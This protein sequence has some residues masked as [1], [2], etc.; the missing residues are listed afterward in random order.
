MENGV[1]RRIYYEK[2]TGNVIID[3]G[4]RL[5]FV[6]ETTVDEDF[7]SYAA[8]AER[9]RDTVDYIQLEYGQYAQD[10]AECNGYRV[11]PETR[12]LE[13][14]YPDP[15]Q[16]DEPPVYRKSLAEE[17]A[18]LREQLAATNRDLQDIAEHVF[19]A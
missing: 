2:S 12:T 5:G 10:F 15:N 18:E 11:N 16:P 14:S 19:G 9:T 8:L 3:T 6:R 1:G 13:F 17:N 7:A 4:E